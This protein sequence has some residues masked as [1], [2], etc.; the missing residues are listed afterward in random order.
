M[1]WQE[2]VV[3]HTARY[4]RGFKTKL[5]SPNSTWCIYSVIFSTRTSLF[6]KMRIRSC[7]MIVI[8]KFPSRIFCSGSLEKAF[9]VF[10]RPFDG[11]DEK[12]LHRLISPRSSSWS[13]VIPRPLFC[14]SSPIIINC[15]GIDFWICLITYQS[16]RLL[17]L[18]LSQFNFS[19]W[20]CLFFIIVLWLRLIQ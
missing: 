1:E 17:I 6:D 5:Q 2:V 8:W 9:A 15:F 14:T 12:L 11:I 19:N 4:L 3:R 16:K 13:A 7:S 20:K 18:R 10:N